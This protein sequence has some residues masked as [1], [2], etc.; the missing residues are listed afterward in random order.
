MPHPRQVAGIRAT[1]GVKKAKMDST[2]RDDSTEVLDQYL[3]DRGYIHRRARKPQTGPQRPERIRK[4]KAR[5]KKGSWHPQYIRALSKSGGLRGAKKR[6]ARAAG[7]SYKTVR[8]A[9]SRDNS[10]EMSLITGVERETG[11]WVNRQLQR[12]AKGRI[13]RF[14]VTP[15]RALALLAYIQR[16]MLALSV[17]TRPEEFAE[18]TNENL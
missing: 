4:K 6:A 16:Q 11:E 15:G 2:W 1:S 18:L 13:K 14:T 12:L 17:E 9:L 3:G 8:N 7:V 5:L 10:R